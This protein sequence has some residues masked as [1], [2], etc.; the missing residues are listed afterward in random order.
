M[1]MWTQR[2]TLESSKKVC[3]RKMDINKKNILYIYIYIYIDFSE[4][5]FFFAALTQ[6]S[7]QVLVLQISDVNITGPGTGTVDIAQFGKE[8]DCKLHNLINV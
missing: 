6:E 7:H 8:K 2:L 1:L 5:C 3:K 4:S